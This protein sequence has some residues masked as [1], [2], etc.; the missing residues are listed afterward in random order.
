MQ[1][2]FNFDMNYESYP[3]EE[4]QFSFGIKSQ[5][6]SYT[7]MHGHES[8][9]SGIEIYEYNYKYLQINLRILISTERKTISLV[10]IARKT[11]QLIFDFDLL[12]FEYSP[13]S[14][15][16]NIIHERRSVGQFS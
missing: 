7:G 2:Q 6:H 10:E 14:R 16:K 12:F 1:H 11:V 15:T 3:W 13:L 9:S 4:I 8:V 5:F